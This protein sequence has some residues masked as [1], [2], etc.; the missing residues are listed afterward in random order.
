VLTVVVVRPRV[1]DDTAEA[2]ARWLPRFARI[3]G[4]L[5]SPAALWSARAESVGDAAT[6]SL[7]LFSVEEATTLG[8]EIRAIGSLHAE[9]AL[10]VVASTALEGV[11]T[12]EALPCGRGTTAAGAPPA[13]LS[14]VLL[15][16]IM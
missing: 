13:L 12:S 16:I 9:V 4:V 5:T 1:D 8:A 6:A 2:A 7:A 15:V 10:A 11:A 3:V 14:L